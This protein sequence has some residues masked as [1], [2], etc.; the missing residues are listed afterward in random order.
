M[1]SL[2]NAYLLDTHPLV[3]WM[4]EPG[5]LS[6]KVR[7]ILRSESNRIHIPSVAVLE[8][9]YLIE[10][11]RVEAS[12]Q[13]VLAEIN[14]TPRFTISSFDLSALSRSLVIAGTRDPFDRMILATAHA[15]DFPV[16]TR[17]RWMA[18]QLG[19]HAVW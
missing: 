1:A 3:Y 15:Y 8:F 14:E 9:Q 11:G 5:K 19:K 4:L 17:D 13:D 2:R 18:D 6:A 12:I 10:I 7:K 16:I